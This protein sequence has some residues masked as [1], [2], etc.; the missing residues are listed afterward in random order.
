[1]VTED[2][3]GND[4]LVGGIVLHL[5]SG[6]EEGLLAN[7]P[8]RPLQTLTDKP[9]PGGRRKDMVAP[10]AEDVLIENPGAQ[11]WVRSTSRSLRSGLRAPIS[12]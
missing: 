9:V 12:S 1:M 8:L 7:H 5:R 10:D 4:L 2:D 3:V 11:T 6:H